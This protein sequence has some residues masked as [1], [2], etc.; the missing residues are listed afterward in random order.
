MILSA[1]LLL[2]AILLLIIAVVAVAIRLLLLVVTVEGKSMAPTL[3]SGDRV[4]IL[5]IRS[6]LWVRKGRIVLIDAIHTRNPTYK[7][8]GS[9]RL[10]PVIKRIVALNSEKYILFS[11]PPGEYEHSQLEQRIWDIP[12]GYVFVCGDNDIQSID[13]R[14]WGP[15]PYHAIVGIMLTKLPHKAALQSD[16]LAQTPLLSQGLPVGER[17]PAFTAPTT[18]DEIVTLDTYF[19]Q[20]LLLLF[21]AH[22]ELTHRNMPFL[23]YLVLEAINADISVVYVSMSSQN[24]TREFIEKWHITQTVLFAPCEQNSLFKDY[25]V[26]GVPFYCF[27]DAQGRVQ[28]SGLASPQICAKIDKLQSCCDRFSNP[29]NKED[30]EIWQSRHRSVEC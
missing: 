17:V 1:V 16:R 14:F 22:T 26:P 28:A 7:P 20:E 25:A 29:P 3:E 23:Q 30:E 2:G 15:L 10:K 5:R 27:I 9:L 6:A 4:L 11:A 12:Q 8:I 24:R 18:S 19:G 13:S 21:I